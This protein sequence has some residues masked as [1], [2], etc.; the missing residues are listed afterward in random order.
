[1]EFH[2]Q[3]SSIK[4]QTTYK[5]IVMSNL[6][7]SQ[8]TCTKEDLITKS[9]LTAG[10]KF[11]ERCCSTYVLT[12]PAAAVKGSLSNK[13][14]SS[15][16]R[17]AAKFH[18]KKSANKQQVKFLESYLSSA[19]S[20]LSSTKVNSFRHSLTCRKP[21]ITRPSLSYTKEEEANNVGTAL[22]TNTE[23]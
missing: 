10:L 12:S 18:E 15:T 11:Q 2:W 3:K 14:V 9:D 21:E 19:A 8:I 1:M 22:K 13:F 20:Q 6:D 5:G 7:L 23:P 4:S 16:V 17:V